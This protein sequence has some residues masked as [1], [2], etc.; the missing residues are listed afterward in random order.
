[1]LL[2]TSW[3]KQWDNKSLGVAHVALTIA[4]KGPDTNILPATAISPALAPCY[5]RPPPFYFPG[6]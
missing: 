4:V 2:F 6:P 5:E 3:K 1:M